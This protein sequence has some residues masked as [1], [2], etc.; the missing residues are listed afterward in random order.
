LSHGESISVLVKRLQFVIMDEAKCKSPWL[1][2]PLRNLT[3]HER[4]GH[5]CAKHIG[6]SLTDLRQRLIAESKLEASCFW[7]INA[8]KAAVSFLTMDRLSEIIDWIQG[9]DARVVLEGTVP[10]ATSIG[11]IV[12]RNDI[13]LSRRVRMIL[14][15][16]PSSEVFGVVTA[17]PIR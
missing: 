14:Q 16:L 11:Y 10:A 2:S 7:S 8:A 13:L 4:I 3:E 17:F 12:T 6:L 15:R 5:T 1:I 9:I